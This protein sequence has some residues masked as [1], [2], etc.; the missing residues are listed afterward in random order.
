MLLV[1][2]CLDLK[3]TQITRYCNKT[4]QKEDWPQHKKACNITDLL[5]E[6][7]A[8]APIRRMMK[9]LLPRPP[10]PAHFPVVPIQYNLYIGDP[11]PNKVLKHLVFHK[12]I[13]A[14]YLDDLSIRSSNSSPKTGGLLYSKSTENWVWILRLESVRCVQVDVD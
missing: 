10:A 13:A 1:A 5:P 4:H 12:T 3:L 9:S 11:S 8:G 2:V 7:N 6:G 14:S